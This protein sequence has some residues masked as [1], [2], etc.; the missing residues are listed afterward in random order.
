MGRPKG[1]R[2]QA[3]ISVSFEDTD[4]AML[5]ALAHRHKVSVAW[6][7]RQGV[8]GLIEAGENQTD[9]SA[10]SPDFEYGEARLCRT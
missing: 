6:M 3:R 10:A 1:K 4:Y 9:E 2:K 8:Q 5:C 7:V